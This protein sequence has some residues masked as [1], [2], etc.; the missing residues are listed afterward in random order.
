MCFQDAVPRGR[1]GGL[2]NPMSVDRHGRWLNTSLQRNWD[3]V[4]FHR[5][6]KYLCQSCRY[7]ELCSV[8][9]RELGGREALQRA[10]DIVPCHKVIRDFTAVGVGDIGGVVAA[11]SEQFWLADNG[12]GYEQTIQTKYETERLKR[13]R[14]GHITP[15]DD[16]EAVRVV[17]GTKYLTILRK[18][19]LSDW[20]RQRVMEGLWIA[21]YDTLHD[22]FRVLDRRLKEAQR[23]GMFVAHPFGAL[24]PEYGSDYPVQSAG[25]MPLHSEQLWGDLS[26]A[27][28]S[29][30]KRIVGPALKNCLAR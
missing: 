29:E 21:P 15:E 5:H 30:F 27:F 18:Y 6:A 2:I 7:D 11:I 10:L 24:I 22:S 9:A 12:D 26:I 23:L 3:Y 28:E 16:A 8:I 20:A 14:H 13:A 25:I 4:G 17:T 1:V 19:T